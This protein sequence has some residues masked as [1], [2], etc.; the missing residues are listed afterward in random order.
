MRNQLTLAALII[1]YIVIYTMTFLVGP[2]NTEI[3]S[4]AAGITGND[5]AVVLLRLVVPL[6]ILGPVMGFLG[7]LIPQRQQTPYY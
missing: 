4:V 2:L 5:L 3:E 1:G 6:F 7:M